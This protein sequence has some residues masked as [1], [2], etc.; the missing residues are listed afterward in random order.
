MEPPPKKV[1]LS[2]GSMQYD[3]D[4]LLGWAIRNYCV[5]G[6]Q[7][8]PEGFV[9]TLEEEIKEGKYPEA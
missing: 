8:L 4:E 7:S 5:P 3:M 6:G 9:E 1:K 2:D